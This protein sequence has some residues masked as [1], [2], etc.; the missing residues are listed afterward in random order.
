[1]A[2]Q[3][4]FSYHAADRL[5]QRFGCKIRTDIMVDISQSFQAVGHAYRHQDHG[6]LCQ[7]YIPQDPSQRL[8][9]VVNQDSGVVLTVLSHGPM[10]DGIY[11]RVC[12]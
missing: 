9:L 8:V 6:C 11:R 12:H 3:V 10:V 7:A 5:S 1:M 4:Q 2:Q